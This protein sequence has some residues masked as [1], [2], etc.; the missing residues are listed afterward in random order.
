MAAKEF[1]FLMAFTF[2]LIAFI[3]EQVSL[4]N[5]VLF[6][7]PCQNTYRMG[8]CPSV[9]LVY[10]Q[11]LINVFSKSSKVVV[12]PVLSD[13]SYQLNSQECLMDFRCFR[14]LTGIGSRGLTQQLPSRS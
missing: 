8:L 12:I 5:L 11:R 2:G 3:F 7:G 4:A 9:T 6:G 10:I 14:F 13:L 1:L